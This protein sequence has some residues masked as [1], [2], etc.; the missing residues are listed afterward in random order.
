MNNPILLLILLLIL[1]ALAFALVVFRN[2]IARAWNRINRKRERILVEDA[3]KH[4][5]DFEYK[6]INPSVESIAGALSISKKKAA[7]L[8]TKL[9]EMGLIKYRKGNLELTGDGR[10]YALKVVRIHRLWE[11]YLAYET[12]V[13]QTQWHEEA[14]LREHELS[15]EEAE[16]LAAR[17]GNPMIDP[18]GDPIPT[19]KG[20]M[21][22]KQGV[23][24]DELEEGEYAR[25]IHVED[26][27]K[28]VYEQISAY[29][30]LPGVQV[31]ILKKDEKRIIF[32]A[33]GE[34]CTLA[35]P[36]AKNINVIPLKPEDVVKE[37]FNTLD[38][39]GINEEATIIGISKSL[40]GQQRRRLLDFGFVRGTKIKAVL[41]GT[42]G[43]P[44]AYLIRDT[45]V[46]LRKDIAKKIFISKEV[47]ADAA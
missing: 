8:I 42:G 24:L 15:E 46:A 5:Y 45:T 14:E 12:S 30:I 16:L 26:E 19:A 20:E 39:L 35:I 36:F 13:P 29:N 11:R 28:E 38:K 2:P 40:I 31:R 4:L 3:L 41:E 21:P 43:D 9:T 17:L 47:Q 1:S 33:E 6:G 44:T 27:P 22:E 23:A 7:N 37:K 10:A 25:V 18:H 34:E 32:D